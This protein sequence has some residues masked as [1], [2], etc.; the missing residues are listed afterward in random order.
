MVNSKAMW[1]TMQI[2]LPSLKHTHTHTHTHTHWY[3]TLA[4]AKTTLSPLPHTL[5]KAKHKMAMKTTL[6]TVHINWI[7]LEMTGYRQLHHKSST[8]TLTI[9]HT[10]DMWTSTGSGWPLTGNHKLDTGNCWINLLDTITMWHTPLVGGSWWDIN[11]RQSLQWY[12][13]AWKWCVD[14]LGRALDV[15]RE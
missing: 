13:V 1:N 14:W 6:T 9:V 8:C 15:G 4:Y 10:I 11:F 12:Y 2:V 7:P 5:Q 3:W